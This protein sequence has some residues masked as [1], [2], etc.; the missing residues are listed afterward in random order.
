[1]N[2]GSVRVKKSKS[3]QK[4]REW[5]KRGQYFFAVSGRKPS[6]LWTKWKFASYVRVNRTRNTPCF[7]SSVA[8]TGAQC[9]NGHSTQGLEAVRFH[10]LGWY[11]TPFQGSL[12]HNLLTQGSEQPRLTLTELSR[13][14]RV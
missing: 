1:L 7:E 11:V 13:P 9:K 12:G 2:A 10:T 5:I 4:L 14:F 3:H 8:L 6:I